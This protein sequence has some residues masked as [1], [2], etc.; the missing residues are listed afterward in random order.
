MLKNWRWYVVVV[1]LTSG[2]L[3]VLAVGFFLGQLGMSIERSDWQTERAQ[4]QKKDAEWTVERTGYLKRFPEVRAE[5]LLACQKQFADKIEDQ[6]FIK[7]M[8]LDIRTYL[9]ER[10]TISDKRN[11]ILQKQAKVAVVAAVDAKVAAQQID[12]KVS[13][14][15]AKVDA[16]ASGVTSI[17]TKIDKATVTPTPKPSTS[18]FGHSGH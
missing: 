16:T 11:A 17:E 8:V 5:T 13:A 15:V 3:G 1:S 12:K 10:A 4:W 2:M 18:W 9:G 7:G 6:A 14:A